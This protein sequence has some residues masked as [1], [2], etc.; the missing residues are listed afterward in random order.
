MEE[1][2]KK[3]VENIFSNWTGLKMAVEHSF[4]GTGSKQVSSYLFIFEQVVHVLASFS[5]QGSLLMIWCII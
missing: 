3:V 1:A 2:L 4:G 5:L